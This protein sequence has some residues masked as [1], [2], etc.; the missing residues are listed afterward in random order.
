MCSQAPTQPSPLPQEEALEDA[1]NAMYRGV[2]YVY[3]P[4]HIGML[5]GMCHL[6]RCGLC[7]LWAV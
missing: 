5:V 4:L 7:L 2:L 6:L 3:C 1:K